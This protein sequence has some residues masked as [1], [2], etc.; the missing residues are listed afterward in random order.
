MCADTN[1]KKLFEPCKIGIMELKNRIIMPPMCTRLC[2]LWGEVTDN[3]IEWYVRRALGGPGLIIVEVTHVA[4]AIEPLRYTTRMLRAD[5]DSYFPGLF[6][7]VESVHDAGAKIGIQLQVGTGIRAASGFWEPLGRE[8]I[9]DGFQIAPSQIPSPMRGMRVREV[10]IEEIG[11]M[12]K[13]IGYAAKRVKQVG[14]DVIEINAHAGYLVAE[15]MSPYFNKRTDQYG[16]NLNGRLRFLLEIIESVRE[17]V[18]PVFPL[19]VKYN[20]EEALDGGRDI[21][22]AQIIAERLQEESI[23]AISVSTGSGA[24]GSMYFPEGYMVPLAEALK[25]VVDIPIIISG[26]LG[27]PVLAEQILRESKA[28]L[29]GL[30]RPLIADPDWP[31]K[32][33]EGRVKEIRQCMA[34]NDC[35][36]VAVLHKGPIRC[37]V[38]ASAGREREHKVMVPAGRKKKVLVIG[39]GPGGMEA[40]R[41][42]ALR[43]HEVTLY[44]RTNKLGGGQ[45]RLASMPPHKEILEYIVSYYSEIFKQLSNIKIELGKLATLQE[46]VKEKADVVI[47][48]SGA[49]PLI[50]NIPGIDKANVV[51]VDDVLGLKVRVGETVLVVGGGLVGCE[52]ANYLAIQGKKV[53]IVEMLDDVASDIESR[54]WQALSD[55]LSKLSVQIITGSRVVSISNGGALISH[56]GEGDT[57]LKAETIVLACGREAAN[58]L[59]KELEGKVKEIY[60]IGDARKP[61]TIRDAISEGYTIACQL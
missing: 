15:F 9:N 21:K 30:G 44:E 61:R 35:S 49:E 16:G 34:C 46:V 31:K 11:K 3:L 7:L 43:G 59:E 53:T 13:L 4:T 6:K 8:L 2:G 51:S 50:P 20:I 54:V 12:V 48:A 32:V 52:T 57:L 14:F 37:A 26:R 39:A 45:L 33:A 25:Q 60:S 19:I 41:V 17:N 5:D 55:E 23:N 58:N 36:K 18:G 47:I 40:A 29:I 27:N 28:D 1:F 24:I 10:T 56:R 42:A 38:N 22:E